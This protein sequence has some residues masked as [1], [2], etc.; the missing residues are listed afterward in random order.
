VAAWT[1]LLIAGATLQFFSDI[2]AMTSKQNAGALAGGPITEWPRTIP[3]RLKPDGR[4]PLFVATLGDVATSLADGAFD[5][6]RDRVETRDGSVLE[7]YY[8][9]E[10]GITYFEPLDKSVFPLPPSGWCSWYYYYQEIDSDE[11]LANARWLSENLADYGARYIQI[12][13]GWQ[14]TGHGLGENRDWTT[15]DDRFSDVGMDG[16]ADS[17]KALG[18]EAGLWLAPH[19]QS[20]EEV[21]RESGAFLWEPDGSTAA[22]TWEGTYL[23]DPSLPAAHLYLRD[24]FSTLKDWGY[25]YFKIDGQPIVLREFAAKQQFMAGELPEGDS[26]EVA[27]ELYRGTLRT[28]REAVGGSSYL[29]GCWGI[30][31]PGAGILNGSRTAGDIYQ[32]WQGFLVA[33]EAVQRW[34][35]LH[36]IAWY[37]DPDVLLVRPPLTEGMARA[38][39]TIQ[40]LSGQALMASDRMPDLPASRVEMLR[41][42]YPA[43][44]I[45]PLDLFK[46][47][48]VR[49]PVWDLKVNHLEREYDVVA[50]F[51]YSTEDALSRLVSWEELGLRPNQVYHVY[52]FWQGM[53]LGAWDRGVFLVVPPADVRVITIVAEEPRPVLVSTN[54]HITQGWVDLLAL[55]EGGVFTQP[56][57]AGRSRVIA[58]DPYILTVGLPR[59]ALTFRLAEVTVAGSDM[60]VR[61]SWAN[62]QGYATV[63]VE[64][65]VTQTVEWSLGFAAAEP[66]IYPVVSPSRLQITQEGIGGATLRWPTQYHVKAGYVIEVDGESVGTAFQPWARLSDLEPLNSYRVGIRSV[67]YDGRAGESAAEVTY[68]PEIPETVYVSDLEPELI[69]QDWGSLGRDLSVDGNDLKVAGE[70]F[71]KGVGTHARSEIRYQTFGAFTRFRARVGIDDEVES[72]TP[73]AV[74]FEVW[75]DDRRLWSSAPIQNGREALNVD[76]DI[77]GVQE[78]ILRVLPGGDS[79]DYNHADWLDAYLVG[80]YPG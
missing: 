32:G 60:P 66:Y 30:P 19:G 40:G 64:S 13:D 4:D 79:I 39:S 18:L 42:V 14:G 16:L 76:V 6:V 11:I 50:L 63:T 59:D 26:T 77:E 51:N 58:G 71:Q 52:D 62:H 1:L 67:W 70:S 47:D 17:I 44:D 80:V 72:P 41:R 45:R 25:D 23:L 68:T 75:G 53:Y 27:A 74:I 48:N 34:N 43:V 46:P 35:F 24:L 9:N 55:D 29:L 78:L 57:L 15:I 2:P 69:Q 5:P 36:N 8:K 65:D 10:L 28:I 33:T 61:T 31:L 21:A 3:V 73:V 12:D 20:N 54:R 38:W 7:N 37:S 49:K 22:D 56:T